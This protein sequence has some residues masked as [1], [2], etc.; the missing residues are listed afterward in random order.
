M[1]VLDNS[2][3]TFNQTIGAGM[4]VCIIAMIAALANYKLLA[5]I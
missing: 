3:L 1:F 2:K 4:L 5:N